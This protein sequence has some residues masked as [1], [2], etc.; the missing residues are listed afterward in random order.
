[1]TSKVLSSF[2]MA[3][4]SNDARQKRR[5]VTPVRPSEVSGDVKGLRAGADPNLPFELI[6]GHGPS[7]SGAH[8]Q[9][10][11]WRM[12]PNSFGSLSSRE[13]RRSGFP[14]VP[15]SPAQGRDGYAR[16]NPADPL[17]RIVTCAAAR[18]FW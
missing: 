2:R 10:P 15:F 18:A 5:R 17:D 16:E 1:V 13:D 12:A 8:Q 4:F 6:S 7:S 14:D 11:Q 9:H 3:A